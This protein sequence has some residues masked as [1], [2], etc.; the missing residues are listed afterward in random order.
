ML[1]I[2][3][4]SR[5]LLYQ[6]THMKQPL[7]RSFSP[8]L[9]LLPSIAAEE[10]ASKIARNSSESA[11]SVR[12]LLADTVEKLRFTMT[13]KFVRIFRSRDAHITVALSAPQALQGEFSCAICHPSYLEYETWRKSQMKSPRFSKQS[14]STE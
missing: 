14:F 1:P 2:G 5:W 10:A 6:S 3:S 8:S 13:R 7:Q 11:E 9:Q 4:T 12:P